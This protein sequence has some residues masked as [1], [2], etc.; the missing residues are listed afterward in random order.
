MIARP[1]RSSAQTVAE[2]SS[3]ADV[4]VRRRLLNAA[5]LTATGQWFVQGHPDGTVHVLA[6]PAAAL[7][8]DA[9]IRRQP[10][11]TRSD[12]R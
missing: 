3:W 10:R 6:G 11:S 5:V 2:A 1:P 12:P 7:A 9:T 4:L 8:L